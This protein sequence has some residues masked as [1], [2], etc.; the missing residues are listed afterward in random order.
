MKTQT[1][2]L[3]SNFFYT[4]AKEEN[5]L[6]NLKENL[7]N[8]PDFDPFI[9]FNRLDQNRKNF[10][11]EQN[12]I[13]FIQLNFPEIVIPNFHGKYFILFYD[14]TNKLNINYNEFLNFILNKNFYNSNNK[15]YFKNNN[16]NSNKNFENNDNKYMSYKTEK[17]FTEILYEEFNLIKKLDRI[18][19]Y[20]KSNGDFNINELMNII[21]LNGKVVDI[22][23]LNNFIKE[24]NNNHN[25]NFNE[26]NLMIFKLDLKKRG[27]VDNKD[28]EKIFNFTFIS[29]NNDNNKN[30]NI[31]LNNQKIINNIRRFYNKTN[32]LKNINQNNNNIKI[33]QSFS[34]NNIKNIYY[35]NNNKQSRNLNI[36]YSLNNTNYSI[37]NQS[38]KYSPIQTYVPNSISSTTL[39]SNNTFNNNNNKYNNLNNNNNK[40]NN[41]SYKTI[42]VSKNLYLRKSPKRK[43]SHFKRIIKLNNL[44]FNNNNIFTKSHFF[45]FI[46]LIMNYELEIE[47][48]KYEISF[49]LDYN[50]EDLFQIFESKNNLN[51]NFLT[52]NDLYNGF[53]KI[54]FL[55]INNNDLK[56]FINRFN[57]DDINK[58]GICY[59]DFFDIYV[60]FDTIKRNEIENRNNNYSLNKN[61]L[62]KFIKLNELIFKA[63][64]HIENER[65]KLNNLI[66]FNIYKCFINENNFLNNNASDDDLEMYF[67][68]NKIIFNH[69][70]ADLLFIRLDKNRDGKIGI[71]DFIKETKINI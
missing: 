53:K 11:N 51:N 6:E 20:I 55:N 19:S 41:L 38:F 60:T 47:N 13:N 43:P 9:L 67:I 29:R 59:S 2:I 45:N 12:F 57:I 52:Y 5:R 17:I 31:F 21:S 23:K 1:K 62:Q 27:K 56:L 63:E 26:I 44:S 7:N 8:L 3:I 54:G 39:T 48:F 58:E 10:L 34:N 15:N 61:T 66:G 24:F 35:N 14:T 49:N 32:N 36:N 42:Q 22:N 33:N 70:A 4:I 28:L 64:K 37:N 16:N 30:K 68:R 50:V 46:K 69:N 25:L 40:Y 71:I 65:I 18:L